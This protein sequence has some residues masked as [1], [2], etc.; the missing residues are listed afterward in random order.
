MGCGDGTD[1]KGRKNT[2]KDEMI[3]NSTFPK[4]S[5]ITTQV[6]ITAIT[7]VRRPRKLAR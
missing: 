4:S 2:M 6:S 1:R 7:N 5:I 3:L